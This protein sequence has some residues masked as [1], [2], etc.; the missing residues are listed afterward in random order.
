MEQHAFPTVSAAGIT[1]KPTKYYHIIRDGKVVSRVVMYNIKS[2]L[3]AM[4]ANIPYYV[5]DGYTNK[6]R[7][8]MLYP[9]ICFANLK[10]DDSCPRAPRYTKGVLLK[11]SIGTNIETSKISEYVYGAVGRPIPALSSAVGVE[12]VLPRLEN[13]LD[14]LICISGTAI[15]HYQDFDIRCFRPIPD[16][17]TGIKYDL[18]K[19]K[20]TPVELG[21]EDKFREHIL[22]ALH[23]QVTLMKAH[24]LIKVTY[25][26]YEPRPITDIDFNKEINILGKSQENRDNVANYAIISVRLHRIF[27]RTVVRFLDKTRIDRAAAA[28]T[29]PRDHALLRSIDKVYNFF[30]NLNGLLSDE[31]QERAAPG[32][33]L[34]KMIEFWG[35]G[36]QTAGSQRSPKGTRKKRKLTKWNLF[37]KKHKLPLKE[38]AVLWRAQ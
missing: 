37:V 23:D 34:D 24:R 30:D 20:R 2:T 16:N 4:E 15:Q 6:L 31:H 10:G 12:S 22:I 7:A 13:L 36:K 32:R 19:C 29:Q 17:P 9:F 35:R 18:T 28:A 33:I 8:N 26:E 3:P 1:M 27:K 25:H 14:Y 21:W 11:Y 5:S 38:A